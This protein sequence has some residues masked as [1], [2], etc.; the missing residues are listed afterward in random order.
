MISTILDKVGIDYAGGTS[1][2]VCGGE[3]RFYYVGNKKLFACR[4]DPK[5]WEPLKSLLLRHTDDRKLVEDL[6]KQAGSSDFQ[7]KTE[8][9]DRHKRRMKA[10]FASSKPISK[11]GCRKAV[12]YIKSRTGC[13]TKFA[14]NLDLRSAESQPFYEN[15]E[16]VGNYPTIVN[17]IRK[18]GNLSSMSLTYLMS[19]GEKSKKILPYLNGS[20]GTYSQTHD[21][22]TG[23]VVVGEGAED[24][25][26]F[27]YDNKMV[28]H[29]AHGRTQLEKYVPPTYVTD[30]IILA[31]N[32]KSY[33]GQAS[34]FKLASKLIG[35]V[36]VRVYLAGVGFVDGMGVD[37]CDT[38]SNS[39]SITGVR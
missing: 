30:L 39:P 19:D 12:D 31:D 37:Y 27:S 9:S 18:N 15:G 14:K 38:M 8:D 36:N 21:I 4:K 17:I 34:A 3:D 26:K 20:D 33:T 11:P 32:D 1:C 24:V 23:R 2:P 25:F 7:K 6:L 10:I 29:I 22:E 35:W 5:H 13:T 28:G 16:I